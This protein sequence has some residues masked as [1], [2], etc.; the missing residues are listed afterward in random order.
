[1]SAK[2][3]WSGRF[4][5]PADSALLAYSSSPEDEI[6]LPFDIEGS[7]AHVT[8]LGERHVIPLRDAHLL[9]KEL[10]RLHGVYAKKPE[11]LLRGKEDVHMAVEAALISALGDTG[12][13]V[14]TA[15]SRN[16]Q[17]ALDLRLYTRR[18]LLS[19][20]GLL[21]SL[22]QVLLKKAERHL[23][24]TMP[25]YTH[26]QRAQPVYLSHWL[27]SHFTALSR[28]AKTVVHAFEITDECPIGAGAIAGTGHDISTERTAELL[29]FSRTFDNSMDATGRRDFILHSLFASA[30]VATHL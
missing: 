23:Q 26:L 30:C 20:Y 4:S 5:L 9:V 15:R 10:R 8:M 17:I 21:N 7:I 12:A 2:Q 22:M 16:D 28:D 1:M 29:G 24:D 6:L 3:L 18:K 27:L 25:A 14:H 13:R 11:A 19:I